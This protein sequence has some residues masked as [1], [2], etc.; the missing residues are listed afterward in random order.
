MPSKSK[1]KNNSRKSTASSQGKPVMVLT[2]DEFP[3]IIVA[4]RQPSSRK[5]TPSSNAPKSPRPEFLEPLSVAL[6]PPPPTPWD[7]LGMLQS[8]YEALMNRIRSEFRAQE[9]REYENALLAEM[10]TPA[11]W[12]RRIEI[13]ETSRETFNRKRGW[14]A[15]ELN[16]VEKLDEEIRECEDQLDLIYGDEDM[17]EYMRD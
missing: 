11:Y 3:S 13:L 5:S 8:E 7:T 10:R 12:L 17:M 9:K 4:S 1:S 14:S 6:P 2:E 15:A 16:Y